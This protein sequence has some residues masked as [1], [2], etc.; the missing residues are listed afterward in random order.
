MTFTQRGTDGQWVGVVGGYT[1]VGDA[2]NTPRGGNTLSGQYAGP[3][4]S[5]SFV[6]SI[7]ALFCFVHASL[8][9]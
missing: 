1:F 6:F 4:G 7:Q 3:F 2:T 5:A 8:V 9:N